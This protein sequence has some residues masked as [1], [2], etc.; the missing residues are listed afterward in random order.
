MKK[1][2][3]LPI[4][5][6]MLLMTL[7]ICGVVLVVAITALFV[8]QVISFRSSFQRDNSTLAAIIANNSAGAMAFRDDG[9]AAEVV[10]S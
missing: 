2:R 7:F 1:F 8:F 6:K 4:Q 9:A 5:Q 3:N 10:N